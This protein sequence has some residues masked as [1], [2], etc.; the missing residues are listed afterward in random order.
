MNTYDSRQK[1]N[2]QSERRSKERRIIAYPFGSAD[3]LKAIKQ[4]YL[5]W[6]KLDRRLQDRRQKLRRIKNTGQ[7]KTSVATKKLHNILTSEEKQ[8]LNELFR[9]DVSE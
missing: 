7:S 5:L 1:G 3:W 4:N 2:R 9:S 8:M 6:P